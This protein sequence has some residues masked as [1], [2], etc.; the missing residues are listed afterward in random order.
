MVV[1]DHVSQ[2]GSKF[3]RAAS[4]HLVTRMSPSNA[5]LFINTGDATARGCRRDPQTRTGPCRHTPSRRRDR[6]CGSARAAPAP[7]GWW[8]GSAPGSDGTPATATDRAVLENSWWFLKKCK[9]LSV[10]RAGRDWPQQ[11]VFKGTTWLKKE[12]VDLLGFQIVQIEKVKW[13]WIT[14]GCLF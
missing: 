3:P 10:S 11:S 1:C 5:M 7:P 4:S 14:Q 2:A 13:L 12:E 6:F 9:M 8:E